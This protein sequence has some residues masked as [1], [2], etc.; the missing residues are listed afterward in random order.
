[1]FKNLKIICGLYELDGCLNSGKC[2]W[3]IEELVITYGKPF[4]RMAI[5]AAQCKTKIWC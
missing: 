4:V 3:Q 1:M 2:R 5:K